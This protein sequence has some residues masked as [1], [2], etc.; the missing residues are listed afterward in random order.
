MT[1][2]ANKHTPTDS[3]TA[4]VGRREEIGGNHEACLVVIR[5]ARLGSRIVLGQQAIVIG[6]S[7]EA[8]FQI[9]D[10]SISRRHC[11]IVR[12]DNDFWIEDLGSTNKTYVNNESIERHLLSDGDHVQL[13]QTVLKFIDEGNIEAGYHS[14]LHETTIRDP[15][16]GLYNRRHLMAVL[17][18]ELAKAIRN[19]DRPLSL[20]IMDI[21]FFKE[22]NDNDGHVAGDAILGQLA[23]VLADRVRDT[24]TLARIG[25]EEFA[26]ILPDTDRSQ[27]VVL[28]E[29]ICNRVAARRY[30]IEDGERSVTLSAGVAQ[31]HPD[32]ADLSGLLR[33]TDERLYQAKEQGRNQ[34]C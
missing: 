34:V 29:E 30:P 27:A 15:L 12:Q 4:F 20:I 11:R 5:G 18:T 31:W 2:P 28:A 6:R 26:I 7:V 8:D 23:R 9:S 3:Q 10:R 14:E 21:D 32:M 25:G 22:I 1:D 16:T 17:E 19:P 13:S 24:D 33:A